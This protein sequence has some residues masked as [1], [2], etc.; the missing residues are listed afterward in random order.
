MTLHN[1]ALRDHACLIVHG[2][3]QPGIV[4][5]VTRADHP[6][7]G[8]HRL[9]RPVLRR[10]ER[11]QL[12]PAGRLPPPR[13]DRRDARDRGRPR[14]RPS[15]PLGLEWTLTDQS[16]PEADGDPRVDVRPLPARAALAAP[17][18]RAAGD[19]PD[20]DLQPHQHRRGRPLVRHPVL[21]RAL[22]GARQVRGRGAR[23]SSCS[24]A[25]STSSCWPATCRSSPRT[26]STRS[27]CR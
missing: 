5:A 25:T 12:L 24:R 10:P 18:R 2:P 8:Q 26:S 15:T 11:R 1:E 21:P 14:P 20:G 3:D 17:P 19:D 4:A 9:A 27:A 7:P 13:P 16:D 23:S 22:A 6:Q